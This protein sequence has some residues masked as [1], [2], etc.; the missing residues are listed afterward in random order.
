MGVGDNITYMLCLSICAEHEVTKSALFAHRVDRQYTNLE[1]CAQLSGIEFPYTGKRVVAGCTAVATTRLPT[2][3]YDNYLHRTYTML[4]M[5][6]GRSQQDTGSPQYNV[7]LRLLGYDT[8]QV[9]D[10]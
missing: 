10:C 6:T 9:R 3:L 4:Y 7:T 2:L 5:F 1:R 8:D